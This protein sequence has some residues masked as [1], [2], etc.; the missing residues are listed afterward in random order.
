MFHVEHFKVILVENIAKMLVEAASSIGIALSKEQEKAF[1]LYLKLLQ[2]KN[3]TTN[4]VAN[5]EE[6]EIIWRH[7]IDSMA[8]P[9][10]LHHLF[11]EERQLSLLD[12]GTGGGFPGIPLKIIYPNLYLGLMEATNKKVE[13]IKEV[14]QKLSLDNIN[15]TWGRA[16]EFGQ[17]EQYRGKYDVVVAR[18]L[19][20]LNTLAELTLPFLKKQGFFIAYKG[21]KYEGE[22]AKAEKAILV[23]GGEV[24]DIIESDITGIKRAF[25]IIKKV[26][27]T[28][29]KYPRRPGI[30]QKRPIL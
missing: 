16:E 28:P 2:N 7:F 26:S 23:L 14:V 1:L 18:A 13:F 24:Q 30:P 9:P 22:L 29:A 10:I 19:A 6:K 5:S 21:P 8:I 3:K 17:E 25:V 4:I 11:T 12:I 15:I 27:T 20:G